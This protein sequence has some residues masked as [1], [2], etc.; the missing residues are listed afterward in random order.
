MYKLKILLFVQICLPA[1]TVHS[2]NKPGNY[3]TQVKVSPFRLL[4]PVHSGIALS[5]ERRYHKKYATQ[6]SGM[7]FT[8]NNF[9]RAYENYKG[10]RFSLE[11][12]YFLPGGFQNEY[13]SAEVIYQK[14]KFNYIT[15]F[16]HDSTVSTP[17]FV[18]L[19]SVQIKRRAAIINLKAGAQFMIKQFVADISVGI[20]I[21]F[22]EVVHKDKLYRGDEM[23]APRHPNIHYAANREKHDAAFNFPLNIM[24]GFMF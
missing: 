13:F 4:D 19:D 6:I 3:N 9:T 21:R 12:K 18:Y 2:Q 5:Y 23:L 8:R 7:Y 24:I 17:S 20:G 22:R 15:S 1:S 14:N 16:I 11:E 10:F